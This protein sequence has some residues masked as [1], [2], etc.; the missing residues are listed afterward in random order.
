MRSLIRLVLHVH[1]RWKEQSANWLVSLVNK[2]VL[3]LTI[4]AIA[5]LAWRWPLL[6]PQVPLWYSKPWGTEQLA[7]YYWLLLLPAESI[8][9]YAINVIIS[10]YVTHE[11]LVFTQIL[12][13]TSL[14]VSL[15][16]L[17]TLVKILFLVT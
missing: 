12:Y 8:V 16:S 1:A 13:L 14:L 4:L 15:L 7:S 10:V 6:P 9:I 3:I 17:I 5:A 11:Y 2:F